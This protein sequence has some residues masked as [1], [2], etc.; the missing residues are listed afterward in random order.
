MRRCQAGA[1]SAG[2]TA[3]SFCG[4]LRL[5]WNRANG[6]AGRRMARG[7]QFDQRL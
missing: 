6:K 7:E 4:S 2:P 1:A 3:G 5:R